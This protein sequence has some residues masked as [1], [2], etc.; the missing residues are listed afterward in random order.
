[1]NITEERLHGGVQDVPKSFAGTVFAL[2]A[3]QGNIVRLLGR[4]TPPS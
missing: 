3:G 4:P 1:M 2:A